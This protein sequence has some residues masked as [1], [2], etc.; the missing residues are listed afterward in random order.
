MSVLYCL[1]STQIPIIFIRRKA[2][3]QVVP[4]GPPGVGP[5]GGSPARS[6]AGVRQVPQAL[7]G[8][9]G[10]TDSYD[11]EAYTYDQTAAIYATPEKFRGVHRFFDRGEQYR[12]TR[13]RAVLP[14]WR[15]TRYY[16]NP[17]NRLGSLSRSIRTIPHS[18]T[19]SE[20]QLIRGICTNTFTQ[21]RSGRYD[22][23]FWTRCRGICIASRHNRPTFS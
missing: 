1:S 16:N 14:A 17:R 7:L 18:L 21:R 12:L 15:Q 3:P 20:I 10:F 5:L 4:E 19:S 6:E 23:S 2:V 13:L 8:H 11:F 22:R 9:L